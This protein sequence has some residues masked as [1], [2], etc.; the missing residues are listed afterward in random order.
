MQDFRLKLRLP[1]FFSI[2]MRATDRQI[3]K[4]M[5]LPNYLKFGISV[6]KNVITNIEKILIFLFVNSKMVKTALKVLFCEVG[7]CC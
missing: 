3:F 2:S 1:S 4:K 5:Y 7:L 6:E